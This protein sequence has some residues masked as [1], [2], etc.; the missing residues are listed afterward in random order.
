MQSDGVTPTGVTVTVRARH[1]LLAGG[2]INNP[3]LLMRSEVPDPHRTVG[4]RTHAASS[5]CRVC[6]V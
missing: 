6:A 4:K 2:G 5:E 3:G 1:V